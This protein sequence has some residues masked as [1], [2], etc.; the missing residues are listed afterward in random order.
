MGCYKKRIPLSIVPNLDMASPAYE[1]YLPL[2]IA[3]CTAPYP[4]P[5][6]MA[7]IFFK[8]SKE[9][10]LNFNNLVLAIFNSQN[11]AVSLVCFLSPVW[12][13]CWPLA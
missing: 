9:F 4:Q 1:L 2:M 12:Q 8:A 3:S 10:R 13:Y 7:E 6:F 5:L 11:F